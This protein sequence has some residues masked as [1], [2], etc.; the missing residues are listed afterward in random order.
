[1]DF[2]LILLIALVV[3]GAIVLLDQLVLAKRRRAEVMVE[4]GA[5][6]VDNGKRGAADAP[7]P[8]IIE[9]ARAFFPVILLVFVLRSFVV[10]PFRIPSGSMYPTLNIGD[11]ILVNK[12]HYGVRLPV[13]N[14]KIIDVDEPERG[15]VMVFRYPH[16]PDVNFIKRVV[17]VPGDL[18]RYENKRIYV[19]GEMVDLQPNGTY[20]LPQDD[21]RRTE[22]DL[23][24]ES[25]GDSTHFILNDPSRRSRGMEVRVPEGSYFM[26][27]DNRDHSNDSRFWGFVPEEN[28]VGRAFFIWF[29]WDSVNGGGVNWGR[30]GNGIP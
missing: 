27:G 3:T 23:F 30:I 6:V 11:F 17:G 5:S 1:M 29:S 21:G 16:D 22:T 9:Y 28:I 8:L 18:I 2:S 19:N 26:M 14:N 12:F 20:L 13:I 24:Q 7:M 4:G 10:E 15:E 25:L